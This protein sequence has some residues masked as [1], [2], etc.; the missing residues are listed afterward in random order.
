MVKEVLGAT[1]KTPA[2]ECQVCRFGRLRIGD[3]AWLF[4]YC[5][6]FSGIRAVLGHV[7]QADGGLASQWRQGADVVSGCERAQVIRRI[8][9]NAVTQST[10]NI[11]WHITLSAPRTCTLRPPWWSLMAALTRSAVLRSS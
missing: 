2:R 6:V 4:R 3:F 8:N 7:G 5:L 1:C 11:R 10:P 9:C